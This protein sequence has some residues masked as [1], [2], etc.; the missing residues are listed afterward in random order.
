MEEI[1][2]V[3]QTTGI[4]PSPRCAAMASRWRLCEKSR[5]CL[6]KLIEGLHQ[7]CSMHE[8]PG[9]NPRIMHVFA[10]CYRH[11]Y[12]CIRTCAQIYMVY[13][14]IHAFMRVYTEIYII[15]LV[16]ILIYLVYRSIYWFVLSTVV[17]S[18]EV[19]SFLRDFRQTKENIIYPSTDLYIW[20]HFSKFLHEWRIWWHVR[21]Q[22]ALL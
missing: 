4:L 10:K 6:S 21:F 7:P 13:T 18:C 22:I 14:R 5:I 17:A 11:V 19:V 9:S 20:Q 12:T 3:S 2:L 1:S 16:Y 8:I 15:I